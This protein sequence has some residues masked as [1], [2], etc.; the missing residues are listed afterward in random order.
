M[1]KQ[2]KKLAF[3]K[4]SITE[5]ND[6]VLTSVNGGSEVSCAVAISISIYLAT[7]A[8]KEYLEN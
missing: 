3:N 8:I 2:N 1:K 7:K 5:L 4:A 6:T